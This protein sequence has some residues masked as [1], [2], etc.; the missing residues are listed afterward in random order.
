MVQIK[1]AT[2]GLT[3]DGG[4]PLTRSRIMT[5]DHDLRSVFRLGQPKRWQTKCGVVKESTRGDRDDPG[6]RY[7]I[8]ER[9]GKGNLISAASLTLPLILSLTYWP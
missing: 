6:R 4:L 5:R 3:A 2:V 7:L 1:I 9:G 8:A